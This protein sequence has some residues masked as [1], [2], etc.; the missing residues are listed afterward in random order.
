MEVKGGGGGVRKTG[1][2]RY[3]TRTQKSG[4]LGYPRGWE[5]A[6]KQC[7]KRA[8]RREFGSAFGRT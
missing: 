7:R 6:C 3:P 8:G 2:S 4:S 1:V 5:K